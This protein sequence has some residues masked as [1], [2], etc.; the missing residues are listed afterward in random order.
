MFN[1]EG[2]I[3]DNTCNGRCSQCGECC[4]I[5]LPLTKKE[6][7]TIKEYVEKNNIKP[8]EWRITPE[9]FHERC[10]FLT[11]DKKCSIYEVRPFTCRNFKC[12]HKDWRKR[13]EL[14]IKRADYNGEP[15]KTKVATL[16]ELVL[17]N[18]QPF[19]IIVEALMKENSELE[20]YKVLNFFNRLDILERMELTSTD[21]ELISGK[22]IIKEFKNKN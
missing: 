3:T 10:C 13:K 15:G 11:E 8:K 19:M 2:H 1:L 7:K 21:G 18:L 17:N 16:D 22:D 20:L 12:N 5:F 6:V 9:G 4:T 14:Y